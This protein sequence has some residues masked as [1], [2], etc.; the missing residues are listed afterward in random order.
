MACD[1]RMCFG[2]CDCSEPAV[3]CALHLCFDEPFGTVTGAV[4]GAVRWLG[5]CCRRQKMAND[6]VQCWP[7]RLRVR[8]L[9]WLVCGLSFAGGVSS[10]AAGH[11][12]PG[13]LY[14]VRTSS[15]AAGKAKNIDF[16]LIT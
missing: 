13:T 1:L 7:C 16:M 14:L 15:L 6:G 9:M 10:V 5:C 12:V 11:L 8:L 4:G 2:V 3:R